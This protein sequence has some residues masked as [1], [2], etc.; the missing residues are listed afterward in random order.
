MV[1]VL[2]KYKDI[3]NLPHHESFIHKR[4]S[5]EERA[6]Q[7]GAF[8]A[9]TGYKEQI[10][11]TEKIVDKKPILS[12]DELDELDYKWK[13]LEQNFDQR[14]S[15]FLTYFLKDK[16][17]NGGYILKKEVRIFKIKS[18]NKLLI[19]DEKEEIPLKNILDMTV[20]TDDFKWL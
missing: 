8:A 18:E 15:I 20:F 5:L 9:L 19:T 10:K 1:I 14:P 16:E 13:W 2:D 3:I 6:Y 4:M 17:E 12:S 11:D 7:F